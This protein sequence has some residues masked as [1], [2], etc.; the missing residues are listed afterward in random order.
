MTHPNFLS[1]DP[2]AV[3]Q[4]LPGIAAA[5][6]QRAS[7]GAWY[8]LGVLIIATVLGAIDKVMMTLLTEPVRHA[9]SLSDTQLGL[10]QGVGLALFAGI[11]TF[12]LGW[13]S[14]RYD[15]RVVLAACVI[16]WSVAAGSRGLAQDFSLLFIASIGVGA[17]EAG[18]TPI[19][20]SMIPDLFSRAQ[21]VLANGIFALSSIFGAALGAMLGGAIASAMDGARPMLPA[22]LQA[23]EG[24]RLSF[25]AVAVCGVPVALLLLSIRLPAR[26]APAV[27]ATDEA[28][29]HGLSFG[30]YLRQHWKVLAGLIVG[31][32]VAGMGLNAV[33]SWIPILAAREFGATPAQVGKGLGLAFIVGTLAGA[34]VGLG[35][36][37]LFGKRMG[38]AAALRIII[39]GYVATASLSVLLL[40]V[41]SANDVFALLALLVTPLISGAVVLPNVLQDVGPPHL[42]SRVIASLSIAALPFHVIGPLLIGLMSDAL[43][44]RPG[45]LAYAVVSIT[46]VSAV[47]GVLILRSCE[48]S[49][50]RLMR[51]QQEPQA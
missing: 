31:S 9:L 17:G 51:L 19:T 5:A 35:V 4:A 29:A 30:D 15:R 36:M 42:R 22:S 44:S 20:N 6:P 43:K 45:G 11:A 50:V 40:F 23:L 25:I 24:W 49:L 21:R 33:G 47:I 32:G 16:V 34:I 48:G 12:P 10:L 14:D 37:R 41:R 13:L 2:A 39:G 3:A 46:L 26:T 38:S 7:V 18:L 28:S 27:R 8:A 1:A